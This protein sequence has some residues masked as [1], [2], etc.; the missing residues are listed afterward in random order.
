MGEM[1]RVGP[2]ATCAWCA[3]EKR[4]E[5]MVTSET[6]GEPHRFCSPRCRRLAEDHGVD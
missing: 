3:E 1:R 2:W 6:L 5:T 4:K